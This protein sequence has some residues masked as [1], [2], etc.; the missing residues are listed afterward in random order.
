M[1]VHGQSS[2]H[3]HT[4]GKGSIGM[5]SFPNVYGD[6]YFWLIP[7]HILIDRSEINRES[8]GPA[9]MVWPTLGPSDRGRL[10]N[11]TRLRDVHFS[12]LLRYSFGKTGSQ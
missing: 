2:I 7:D 3:N 12:S 5:L 6:D 9:S 8:I 11:S 4:L 10:M 1:C